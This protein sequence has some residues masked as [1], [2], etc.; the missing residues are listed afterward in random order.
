M[1]LLPTCSFEEAV[2]IATEHLHNNVVTRV[3]VLGPCPMNNIFECNQQSYPLL[4]VPT[5]YI[6]NENLP[7]TA[8]PADFSEL[9]FFRVKK[10]YSKAI[11]IPVTRL[12]SVERF[13]GN[14]F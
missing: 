7:S 4:K 6:W 5:L 13:H 11:F 2:A 9:L 14:V 12:E 8:S 10:V 1:E 3:I